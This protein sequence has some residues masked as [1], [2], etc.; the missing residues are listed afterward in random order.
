MVAQEPIF[1]HIPLDKSMK[2][3]I[4]AVGSELLTPDHIDSKS[5]FI[6]EKLNESGFE[7]HLKTIVGDNK[8][9]LADLLRQALDRSGLIIICGG[10]GPTEDDLTR[11]AVA[12]ALHRP[13][14]ISP[15]LLEMMHKRFARRRTPMPKINERQAEVIKG[16]EIIENALG[17]APGM[18]LEENGTFVVLLPGPPGELNPMMDTL[19]V[20]KLK[21]LGGGRRLVRKS[22]YIAGMPESEVDAKA[23]PIYSGYHQIRTT[24]LSGTSHISLFFSRWIEPG[25][26]ATDLDELA[27]RVRE[28]LGDAVFSTEGQ[29]L[30]QV[31]GNELRSS[32]RTLAIAESCTSGMIG[33]RLTRVPGSSDY[34][35]G[36]ILCYSNDVKQDLC[37]VSGGTLKKHGAVSAETAEE[38]ARGVRLALNSSIGLSITGIAGPGGSSAEKPIGLVYVALSDGQRMLSHRRVI[39]GDRDSIRERATY[40]A[41]FCLHRFL[42]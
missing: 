22:F 30:E 13:I 38:L 7:V 14:T 42:I 26:E 15:E 18:W 29:S 20:P 23:A 4:I 33:M 6:T 25:E 16:A 12:Q 3:E 34:F 19:I 24:I 21:A 11:S 32:K 37:G 27:S 2:A 41:L 10:L 8:E 36:G 1:W 39:P 5:L 35:M 17:T 28:I 9:E 40:F 31:V